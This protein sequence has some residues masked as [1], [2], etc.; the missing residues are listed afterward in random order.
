[1]AFFLFFDEAGDFNFHPSA[2]RYCQFGVLSTP[3]PERLSTALAHLQYEIAR[4]DMLVLRR[5]HAA[6]DRQAVRDQVFQAL[7]ATSSIEFDVVLVDKAK[8]PPELRDLPRFYPHLAEIAL[9]PVFARNRSQDV[10]VIT[11]TLPLKRHAS[12]V[13]KAFKVFIRRHVEGRRFEIH[14]HPSF[15][16]AGLQ[17]AD[18]L[19]WAVYRKWSRGDRRSYDLIKHIVRREIDVYAEEEARYY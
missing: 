7:A 2:S 18:Y 9:G 17:A 5:F 10:V 12:A 16:H 4:R 8:T 3:R 11:D 15:A 14:H 13:E 19:N 6:E 1:M